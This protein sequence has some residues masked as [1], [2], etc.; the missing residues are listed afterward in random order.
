MM[1]DTS[2]N[3]KS[4]H[5]RRLKERF[6]IDGGNSMA[7]YELLE[8][9]LMMAIPRRDVKPIAKELLR[10]FGS[11]SDVIYANP[12]DLM[13]VKWVKENT[14]A[15]FQL[16][17]AAVKRVCQC[18]MKSDDVP[19]LP[20]IDA[21]VDYC[22]AAIAYAEVEELHVIFLDTSFKLLGV[23]LLRKGTLTDVSISPREVVLAALDKKASNIILVHNHPSDNIKPSDND[24]RVTAKINEACNLMGIKLQDHIIIGKS[25]FFSFLR[26]KML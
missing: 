21:V 4:G 6:L 12:N 8:F 3:D 1:T 22:R 5:R 9:L 13:Q 16:V 14:C 24:I 2:I 26:H 15:L 19:L 18:K 7:D 11:F 20:T 23:E 10:K 17:A 25:D